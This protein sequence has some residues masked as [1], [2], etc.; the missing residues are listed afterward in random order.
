MAVKAE[1]LIVYVDAPD[2]CWQGLARAGLCTSFDDCVLPAR[3]RTSNGK[4]AVEDV[5]SSLF[6]IHTGLAES[7]EIPGMC[8]MNMLQNCDNGGTCRF[9]WQEI[10]VFHQGLLGRIL[11]ATSGGLDYINPRIVKTC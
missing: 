10:R 1:R 2:S 6:R 3:A 11:P 7:T 9:Y 8:I 4:M 5:I